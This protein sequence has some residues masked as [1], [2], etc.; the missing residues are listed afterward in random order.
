MSSQQRL[1]F[2]AHADSGCRPG[3]NHQC[4]SDHAR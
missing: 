2:V 1:L 3:P 4:A